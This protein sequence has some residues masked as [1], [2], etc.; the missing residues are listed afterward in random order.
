MRE[1]HVYKDGGFQYE[2]KYSLTN[3]KKEMHKA[4]L[5]LMQL[6][7]TSLTSL[8]TALIAADGTSRDSRPSGH[9]KTSCGDD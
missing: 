9:G 7:I 5:Q 1:Y 4:H 3:T 6:A 2:M 8:F